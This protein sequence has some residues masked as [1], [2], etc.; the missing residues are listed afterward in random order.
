[1]SKPKIEN[2][3]Y[4]YLKSVLNNLLPVEY[5]IRAFK[6]H[7]LNNFEYLTK[8]NASIKNMWISLGF[9][10]E[11]IIREDLLALSWDLIQDIPL[12][13]KKPSCYS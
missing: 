6:Q 11:E 3:L 8:Q 10:N 12:S 9:K 1:M 2:T 5:A 4:D 7:D 13:T